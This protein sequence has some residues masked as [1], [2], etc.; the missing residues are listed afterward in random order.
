MAQ[1]IKVK[2]S[3]STAAPTALANGELAYSHVGS[4]GKL[5]IGRPGGS[6]G[7]VDAIGGKYYIDR[8]ETAYGWGD[9]STEGYL[10]AGSSGYNNTQWDTA[11]TYSQVGHLPL[12]GGTMTGSITF[13]SSSGV[14]LSNTASLWSSGTGTFLSEFGSGNLDIM[15]KDIHFRSDTGGT[16]TDYFAKFIYNGGVEL[17]HDGTKKVETTSTG[18]FVSGSLAVSGT[19]DG[20]DVAADGTKLDGIAASANNYSL[21]LAT[22]SARG[23][24]ELFSN[25]DQSVAANTITATAN[26]T[27]GIQLN[28]ANQAVVNVPWSDTNTDTTYSV[29][30][31]G[32]T[33]KNF[34]T[35]LKNKLDGIA[36]SANNY[37]LPLGS[38]TTRGGV[39]IGYAENGKNY[40]VEL[41]SEKMYVNVPWTDTNTTYSVGDGGLTQ[42]NFTTTLKSKLDGIAASA[43]N[44]SLPLA[45][46]T[47]R[48]GIELFSTTDQSVAANSISTAPARTYGI[49]LNSADQAVVNVP[50][51]DTN[52]TYSVG[53]GGLTQKNFTTTLKNKLDGIATSANNYSLSNLNSHLSGGVGNIVTSGYIRGPANMVIDPAA[54]GDD[55]GTLTIAGNLTVSGT[56]TTIN[57]NIVSV[58]DSV[59]T[60][61]SDNVGAPHTDCGFLVNRGTSTDVSLL[62]NETGDYFQISDGATT[63]KILTAAN[64]A[65][66]FT[67]TLDGGTF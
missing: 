65:A 24:I 56:T 60:L 49:Q 29:G 51:T 59:I 37:S 64:F 35:T 13:P 9:H 57:S 10:V 31:G 46:A 41:S 11:H 8:S 44:Y 42:K 61:N 2:R 63:S 34:T 55:T 12:S 67:G 30:D 40:P 1:T 36:A 48:G 45:T 6:T 53:D 18:L 43:N 25:T 17:Y 23:G 14:N 39:K 54:H 5:Y 4:N 20:R 15:A 3:T 62:W 7:D 16:D 28:S 50:W 47:A 38:S 32:L 26:R 52:T 21:P 66:S 27:Y 19:V 58:G 33:Q 22:A